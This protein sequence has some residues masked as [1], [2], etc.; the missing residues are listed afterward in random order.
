MLVPNANTPTSGSAVAFGSK[1]HLFYL[2]VSCKLGDRSVW[3]RNR[4]T[5]RMQDLSYRYL[6]SSSR[7]T[8]P[9]R[10]RH[11]VTT[12]PLRDAHHSESIQG[13]LLIDPVPFLPVPMYPDRGR[14]SDRRLIDLKRTKV[15]KQRQPFVV[16][17][18]AIGGQERIGAKKNPQSLVAMSKP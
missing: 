5:Y 1:R 18:D 8:Y 11:P 15:K 3:K 2:V 13:N 10:H 7:N 14:G 4:T 6:S 12:Q 16:R 17:C 9:S